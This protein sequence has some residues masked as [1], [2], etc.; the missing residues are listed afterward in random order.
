MPVTTHRMV[1]SGTGKTAP[2]AALEQAQ[3]TATRLLR[4]FH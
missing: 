2:E 1:L 3:Y 4:A